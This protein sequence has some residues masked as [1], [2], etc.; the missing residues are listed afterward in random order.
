MLPD[1]HGSLKGCGIS[2]RHCKT[3]FGTQRSDVAFQ[4]V[5]LVVGPKLLQEIK[6]PV[7]E[8]MN[9]LPLALCNRP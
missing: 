1:V 4:H 9:R 3:Q 8:S 2:L 7:A 5:L 6:E